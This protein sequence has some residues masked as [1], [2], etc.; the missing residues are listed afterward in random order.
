MHLKNGKISSQTRSPA[1]PFTRKKIYPPLKEFSMHQGTMTPS[2]Q[3]LATVEKRKTMAEKRKTVVA[4]KGRK[5]S[6]IA[7][8]SNKET[9]EQMQPASKRKSIRKTINR[10]TINFGFG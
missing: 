9:A 1:N 6:S 10:R 3:Q 2:Q 5:R 7:T 4:P 8:S